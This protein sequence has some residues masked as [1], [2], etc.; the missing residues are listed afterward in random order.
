MGIALS[1]ILLDTLS[2]Y[3]KGMSVTLVEHVAQ[4]AIVQNHH[5][6]QVRLNRAQILDERAMSVCTVLPVVS[7]RKELALLL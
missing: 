4:R 6:T 3:L 1:T 2:L 5:L 7:A